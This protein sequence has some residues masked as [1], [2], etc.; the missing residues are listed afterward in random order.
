MLIIFLAHLANLTLHVF[1]RIEQDPTDVPVDTS[2]S[3]Q[4]TIALCLK[5][6]HDQSK[7]FHLPG[8][9]LA[10]MKKRVGVDVRYLIGE[11]FASDDLDTDID[12]TDEWTTGQFQRIVSELVLPGVRFNENPKPWRLANMAQEFGAHSHEE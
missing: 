10:V 2:E 5:G 4:S 6:L 12:S 9:L 11:A 8:V 1:E 7:N 3:V